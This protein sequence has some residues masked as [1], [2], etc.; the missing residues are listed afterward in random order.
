[1]WLVFVSVWCCGV[2]CFG[3]VCVLLCCG[4]VFVC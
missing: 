4:F 2:V 1:V 3:E